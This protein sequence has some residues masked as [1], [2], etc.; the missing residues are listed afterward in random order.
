MS[1]R[2]PR[3]HPLLVALVATAA[4]AQLGCGPTAGMA[5]DPVAVA[6]AAAAAGK[7][8]GVTPPGATTP[9][10]TPSG[11]PAGTPSDTPSGTPGSTEPG[12]PASPAPGQPTPTPSATAST[13]AGGSGGGSSN[14]TFLT[15]SSVEG[16]AKVDGV[17]LANATV[18]VENAVT[19]KVAR[20]GNTSATLDLYGNDTV[21]L[22]ASPANTAADG[23]Y[24]LKV[25]NLKAGMVARITVSDGTKTVSALVNGK[26]AGGAYRLVQLFDDVDVNETSLLLDLM[27]RSVLSLSATLTESARDTVT[28]QI[29]TQLEAIRATVQ[30]QLDNNPALRQALRNA[31]NTAKTTPSDANTTALLTAASNLIT[32]VPAIKTAAAEV[33]TK[34]VQKVVQ[35]QA[36]ASNVGTALTATAIDTAKALIP[37]GIG[38]TVTDTDGGNSI[39]ITS[40]TTTI[41]VVPDPASDAS[42]IL[43]APNFTPTVSSLSFTSPRLKV[44]VTQGANQNDFSEI[45]ARV[46]DTSTTL[47]ADIANFALAV[48]S[49]LDHTASGT[50]GAP[51]TMVSDATVKNESYTLSSKFSGAT[52]LTSPTYGGYLKVTINA[53]TVNFAKLRL[54]TSRGGFHYLVISY[55]TFTPNTTLTGGHTSTLWLDNLLQ[56]VNAS[57]S[58][59]IYMKATSGRELFFDKAIVL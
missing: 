2:H 1:R 14:A 39:T 22:E 33:V 46:P 13:A 41:S 32:P 49:V 10:T 36:T 16:L 50:N 26:N 42:E 23:K 8:P 17:A 54:F 58:A 38:V 25:A 4:A 47:G 37:T 30:T 44:T 53:A 27:A 29:K 40:G 9:S 55:N 3:R 11:A 43:T 12:T 28:T 5:P 52:T 7:A 51:I 24:T 20:V 21:V 19:G 35:Q 56:T 15:F 6:A 34:G 31:A 48:G 59:K 45:V 18:T 57:T